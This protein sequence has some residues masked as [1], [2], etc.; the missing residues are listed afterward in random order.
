[1]GCSSR[2]FSACPSTRFVCLQVHHLV[3]S[4]LKSQS[5][6]LGQTNSECRHCTLCTREPS[7]FG[8]GVMSEREMRTILSQEQ[9]LAEYQRLAHKRRVCN[10]HAVNKPPLIDQLDPQSLV[11]PILHTPMGYYQDGD[12]LGSVL[13]PSSA[14]PSQMHS[15]HHRARTTP[16]SRE[17]L[18][19]SMGGTMSRH[20]Q[21]SPF[22]LF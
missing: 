19:R 4:D 6:M 2:S 18:H 3:F 20:Q 9:S 10:I 17:A 21:C 13:P 12:V 5:I 22:H 14:P 7:S 16:A 8:K 15:M 11:V 1:M